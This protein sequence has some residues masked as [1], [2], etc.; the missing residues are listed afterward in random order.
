MDE[1]LQ[2]NRYELR[3]SGEKS[4]A[5]SSAQKAGAAFHAADVEKMPSVHRFARGEPEV[6]VAQ[7]RLRLGSE[8]GVPQR[9]LKH[10]VVDPVAPEG[11]RFRDAYYN[12]VEASL[13]MRLEA[14]EDWTKVQPR[15]PGGV[16]KLD[17]AA[18][19]DLETLAFARP[20]RAI[21]AW[22]DHVGTRDD[23]PTLLD[24]ETAQVVTLADTASLKAARDLHEYRFGISLVADQAPAPAQTQAQAP[25]TTRARTDRA[26]SIGKDP[27]MSEQQ[28]AATPASSERPAPTNSVEPASGL[29]HAIDGTAVES[30]KFSRRGKGGETV[31]DLRGFIGH[32]QVIEAKGVPLAEL[33][34]VV[35]E[36]A[37]QHI[38]AA[39]GRTGTLKTER[40]AAPAQAPASAATQASQ[41]AHNQAA[42]RSPSAA[43]APSGAAAAAPADDT[44]TL[45]VLR[46]G[47]RERVSTQVSGT[48]GTPELGLTL[49]PLQADEA[50][51]AGVAGGLLVGGVSAAADRAGVLPGD[52]LV[53]VN[54]T[55]VS[56][57]DQVRAATAAARPTT[58]QDN[59]PARQA[60]APATQAPSSGAAPAQAPTPAAAQAPTIEEPPAVKA[61]REARQL[62]I[63]AIRASLQ[64]RFIIRAG[65]EQDTTEY[66]F[67][68]EPAVLA[69]VDRGTKLATDRNEADVARG[70]VDLAQAKGWKALSLAG[71]EDFRRNVW[72]EAV[73]R[74]LPAAGYQPTKV[75]QEWVTARLVALQTNTAAHVGVQPGN[76]VERTSVSAAQ[77][78]AQAGAARPLR[79]PASATAPAQPQRGATKE[80]VMGAMRSALKELNTDAAS[81]QRVM[82]R[83]SVRL[84]GLLAQGKPLPEIGRY[85]RMAASQM[86][87][88]VPRQAAHQR[89]AQQVGQP[90]ART[91]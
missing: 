44:V 11:E 14:V 7:T 68:G 88:F 77:Q 83:L 36:A 52:V 82:D 6:V 47:Q 54:G 49:R 24:C 22:M 37:A 50:R 70:I 78:S 16:W 20:E 57:V 40:P 3:Q 81:T 30:I 38:A 58:A 87:T 56:S 48:R 74:G 55:P 59:A 23:A 28:Q 71:T 53:S 86:Q 67:K 69:F 51:A 90:R 66:R 5:F 60:A 42:A 10:K 1:S 26:Q 89:Q 41:P 79:G 9:I 64:E 21:Q 75:D 17:R 4:R 45:E 91:R 46:R 85:D 8:Y 32:E 76:T 18:Y 65:R 13:R 15:A 29:A 43:A 39:R 35:G 25:A 31:A 61:R 62:A 27:L 80:Q 72:R 33:G 2:A 34:R 84:D 73:V 63:E 19:D 12:A